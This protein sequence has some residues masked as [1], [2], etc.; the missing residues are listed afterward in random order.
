M[1]HG[2]CLSS[3]TWETTPDGRM[4]WNEYFVRRERPVYLADQV[5]RA[6]SGFDP[7]RLQP[8]AKPAQPP[9]S[10]LPNI[11]AP[12]SRSRGPCSASARRTAR[13]FRDGQF[14][15]EARRRALQADDSRS[16][17]AAADSPN[18]TWTNMAALASAERRGPDGH[19]ESGF[20][21]RTGRADRQRQHQGAGH[22]R[23]GRLVYDGQSPERLS[24]PTRSRRWRKF[25][26]WCSTG[27]TWR[28]V[29]SG[30]TTTA[31]GSTCPRSRPSGGD[32]TFVSL[33][34]LGIVGNSHMTSSTRTTSRWLTSSWPGWTSTSSS[35]D[36]VDKMPAQEHNASE[37]RSAGAGRRV[38]RAALTSSSSRPS[39]VPSTRAS[40]RRA[41]GCR[42][43]VR[44][45]ASSA[46]AARRSPPL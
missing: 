12:A 10:E 40:W 7:E 39:R 32:I 27:T 8:G 20:F 4:G 3:K 36:C 26:R 29:S 25:R 21:P 1:V 11:I 22:D 31:A 45:H 46:S 17:R 15:I 35:V 33:P 24:R 30:A 9:P 42:R 34:E 18:P 23:A 38:G 44:W 2:C 5:S 16:E 19:S 41:T 43:F 28:G 6:R 13:R 37:H 14:P